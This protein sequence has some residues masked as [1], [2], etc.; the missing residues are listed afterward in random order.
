M[1]GLNDFRGSNLFQSH[2]W[3]CLIQHK[4]CLDDSILVLEDNMLQ[5]PDEIKS[6]VVNV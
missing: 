3:G 1:G 5:V 4:V 6:Y 2:A